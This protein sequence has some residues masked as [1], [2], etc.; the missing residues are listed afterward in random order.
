MEQME[1]NDPRIAKITR[2]R[3]LSDPG[4]P[5]WDWSYGCA[6]TK[7]GTEVR[8]FQPDW[9]NCWLEKK[10]FWSQLFETARRDGVQHRLKEAISL[11]Q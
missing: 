8:L 9:V 5:Y 4:H 6:E 3:F 7:D 2:L 1:W 10:T 11:F